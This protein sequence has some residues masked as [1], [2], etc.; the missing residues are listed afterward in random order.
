MVAR[1]FTAG[2][3]RFR[4]PLERPDRR[5]FRFRIGFQE[6]VN[7]CRCRKRT[8]DAFLRAHVCHAP[9]NIW[10]S[11]ATA[12]FVRLSPERHRRMPRQLFLRTLVAFAERVIEEGSLYNEVQKLTRNTTCDLFAS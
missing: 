10:L 12:A 9:F 3:I 4:G 6:A 5:R 2:E 11:A 7:I 8:G 1:L